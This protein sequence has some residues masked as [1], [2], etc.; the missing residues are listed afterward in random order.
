MPQF[1]QTLEKYISH[2]QQETID[3]NTCDYRGTYQSELDDIARRYTAMHERGQALIATLPEEDLERCRRLY[4][5]RRRPLMLYSDDLCVSTTIA[6]TWVLVPA[7]VSLIREVEQ[8]KE[9][10][11]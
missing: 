7:Y 4:N 2:V 3:G 9:I 5:S 11:A 6:D 10:L 1:V 8:L